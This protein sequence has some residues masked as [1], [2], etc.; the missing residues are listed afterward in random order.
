MGLLYLFIVDAKPKNL[1]RVLFRRVENSPCRCEYRSGPASVV[2]IVTGYG[3]D[4]PGIEF[5][6]GEIFRTCPDRP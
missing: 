1:C 4:G 2:G 6:W 3:L 5:Q